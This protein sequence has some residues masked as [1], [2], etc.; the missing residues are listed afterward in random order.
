MLRLEK[1]VRLVN[2]SFTMDVEA[3]KI[4]QD[5]LHRVRTP[6]AGDRVWK[7]ECVYSFDTP[8]RVIIGLEHGYFRAI[9]YLYLSGVFS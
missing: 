5:G 3:M 9:H 6:G 1:S 8:V 4:L 2:F 7:D